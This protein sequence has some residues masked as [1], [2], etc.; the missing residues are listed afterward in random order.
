MCSVDGDDAMAQIQTSATGGMRRISIQGVLSF[1]DLRKLERACGPAL[2]HA[3]LALEIHLDGVTQI[4][5]SARVYLDQLARRG[6][7]IM[8]QA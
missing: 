7:V 1:K 2:E 8:G 6:A 3:R 4:D 5:E